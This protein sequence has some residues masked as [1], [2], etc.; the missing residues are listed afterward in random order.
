MKRRR[1][2]EYALQFLFQFDFTGKRPDKKDLD[3]FWAARNGDVEVRAF[4]EDIIY[5][6]LDNLSAIDATIQK[7]AE[8]WVLQ[9]M[10][11]V[12]RNILR[13]AT[14]E[15]IFRKDIPSTVTINE[16]IE[17]AKKFSSTEAS[18]FING[19]LDKIAGGI[20]DKRKR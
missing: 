4:S 19:I 11:A 8:N 17:I 14:Y 3:E 2:R 15:L 9:R 1:G 13:C 10:A 7:A 20:K 5:G 18:S 12:D 16:A 6:T